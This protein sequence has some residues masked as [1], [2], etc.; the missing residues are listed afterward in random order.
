[1][2]YLLPLTAVW[3]VALFLF[4]MVIPR[5]VFGVVFCCRAL[6]TSLK[7]HS[8]SWKLKKRE[9]EE[10]AQVDFDEEAENSNIDHYSYGRNNGNATNSMSRSR[11]R[12][13]PNGI[14]Y[15]NNDYRSYAHYDGSNG[16]E[17]PPMQYDLQGHQS[18]Q[19][20][21]QQK[22][23]PPH[24]RHDLDQQTLPNSNNHP[25]TPTTKTTKSSRGYPLRESNSD[26]KYTTKN[27]NKISA[28]QSVSPSLAEIMD[29]GTLAEESLT[30]HPHYDDH[31]NTRRYV[32]N[33]SKLE[34][35]PEETSSEAS[36]SGISSALTSI[37]SS[38][39]ILGSKAGWMKDRIKNK[40]KVKTK[41][42]KS[43]NH[44]MNSKRKN[45]NGYHGGGRGT[46]VGYDRRRGWGGMEIHSNGSGLTEFL[47][48]IEED[49]FKEVIGEDLEA[50]RY[51]RGRGRDYYFDN[52]VD[53]NNNFDHDHHYDGKDSGLGHGN[54]RGGRGD[55]GYGGGDDGG[56]DQRFIDHDDYYH[57]TSAG[58]TSITDDGNYYGGQ[59]FYDDYRAYESGSGRRRNE[60]SSKERRSYRDANTNAFVF[61][62]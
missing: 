38:S 50:L 56:Y 52:D 36:A 6:C 43:F 10:E 26:S 58:F 30:A 47:D 4:W 41:E 60:Q 35:H 62:L 24:F 55:G 3:M 18:R 40:E 53:D 15:V 13:S 48:G 12:R 22:V 45:R 33:E 25:T 8:A 54:D 5:V 37:F 51:G 59:K 39:T 17:L 19:R 46:G 7:P 28:A 27:I 32:Y 44:F 61:T 42:L 23:P 11:Q 34:N 16:R 2:F 20:S 49:E 57:R 1:M 14:R 31:H 9:E 29:L 21:R